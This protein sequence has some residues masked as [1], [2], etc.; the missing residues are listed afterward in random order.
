[1]EV[2]DEVVPSL[3]ELAS[4]VV[5][6]FITKPLAA[7]LPQEVLL[8]VERKMPK[9]DQIERLGTFKRFHRNGNVVS[10][11]VY[12]DQGQLHGEC[13]EWLSNG[14]LESIATYENGIKQGLSRY[15]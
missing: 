7:R 6:L 10:L 2:E 11:E 15:T 14:K 3:K 12:N 8:C 13:K 1:M 9:K 5:A 4:K